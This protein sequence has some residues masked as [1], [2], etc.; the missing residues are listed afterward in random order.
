MSF[1][2]VDLPGARCEIEGNV[3]VTD[4]VSVGVSGGYRSG[5]EAITEL[6]GLR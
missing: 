2:S 4:V 3:G 1:I 5:R 6:V